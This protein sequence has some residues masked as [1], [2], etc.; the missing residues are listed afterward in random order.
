M[1]SAGSRLKGER[2]T[3]TINTAR[4]EALKRLQLNFALRKP[5]LLMLFEKSKHHMCRAQRYG[6]TAGL[7]SPREFRDP[8]R[9]KSVASQRARRLCACYCTEQGSGVS[10]LS[11]HHTHGSTS[12]T[13]GSPTTRAREE[14]CEENTQCP[15][16]SIVRQA[17]CSNQRVQL[18]RY[19]ST[20]AAAVVRG[21]LRRM[22]ISARWL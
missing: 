6:D 15:P 8:R 4:P 12:T 13:R 14:T 2:C 22:P 16:R 17:T 19:R 21:Q 7:Q 10:H 20:I 11:C 9:L 18:S 5:V 3:S 1:G